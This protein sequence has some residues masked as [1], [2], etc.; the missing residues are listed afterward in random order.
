MQVGRRLRVLG[1]RGYLAQAV[2]P[3]RAL[4]AAGPSPAPITAVFELL[5]LIESVVVTRTCDD[6]LAELPPRSPPFGSHSCFFPS[7]WGGCG[8]LVLLQVGLVSGARALSSLSSL[9]FA[10]GVVPHRLRSQGWSRGSR[11]AS[12]GLLPEFPLSVSCSRRCSRRASPKAPV[13]RVTVPQLSPL[14]HIPAPP[15]GGC[16]TLSLPTS[17]LF[18]LRALPLEFHALLTS[19]LQR[20]RSAPRSARMLRGRRRSAPG[21]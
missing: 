13:G 18:E 16:A 5:G 3:E 9:E 8:R 19:R 7:G 14:A 21:T 17:A 12:P 2:P 6:Q 10:G 4:P 11:D 1:Q 20:V 15:R